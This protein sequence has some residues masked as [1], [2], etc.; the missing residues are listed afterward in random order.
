MS[1][2]RMNRRSVLK[3]IAVVSAGSALAPQLLGQE[4][5]LES[6]EGLGDVELDAL[7]ELAETYASFDAQDAAGVEQMVERLRGADLA[8]EEFVSAV[9]KEM[10]DDFESGRIAIL[11]GWRVSRTEARVLA[12]A[13]ELLA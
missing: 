5:K 3:L 11:H 9:R 13:A 2:S 8:D 1:V 10:R 4:A 7:E 12:A 6:F